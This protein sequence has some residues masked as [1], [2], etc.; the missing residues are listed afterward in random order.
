MSSWIFLLGAAGLVYVLTQGVITAPIR[1]IYPPLLGCP[2]CSGVWV[3]WMAAA[4]LAA[5]DRQLVPAWLQMLVEIFVGGF[6][7]SVWAC[8]F[9]VALVTI[10]SHKLRGRMVVKRI[11]PSP[12]KD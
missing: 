5:R 2:M 4:Y 10:G 12:K 9:V 3:G 7:V 6:F 1:K 11:P 8:V